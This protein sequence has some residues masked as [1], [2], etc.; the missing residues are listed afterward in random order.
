[1]THSHLRGAT[2][3]RLALAAAFLTAACATVP[4]PP[5]CALPQRD[6]AW[7][8]R[9]LD[10]WR[11]T[12][13]EITGAAPVA[14]V[15]AIFFSADCVLRS[16]NALSSA[17]AEHVTWSATPHHGKVALPDGSAIDAGVTSFATG[18][19]PLAYFVMSTPTVW[20]AAGVGEGRELETRM[21]AVLLHEGSHVAQIGAYG[22]RLGALIERNQLPDSFND[23]ALQDRF[24]ANAEFAASVQEETRRFLDAAAT[25]D[26][27]QAR[28]LARE[29]LR[30][31]RERQAR[32]QVG[33]DA[34]LAEAEDIWLTFEGAGQYAGYRWLIDPRGGAQPRAEVLARF[35]KGRFWSQTEGFAVVMA[36]E[37]IAGARWKLHAFGDGARTVLEMLDDAVA[38]N[39]LSSRP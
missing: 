1:M 38:G 37:R 18:K 30:L 33:P 13:R 27:A 6:R 28:T 22:P 32:W 31:L 16:G 10:A 14:G 2:V 8:D 24:R 17:G 11:F 39:L 26:D 9:A 29:A 23:D 5:A 20:Q 4:A 36:L 21:I 34:Y 15:Q 7:I 19:K 3:R 25:M 35:T 12:S